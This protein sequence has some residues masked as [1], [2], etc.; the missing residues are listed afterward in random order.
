MRCKNVAS[1]EMLTLLYVVPCCQADNHKLAIE[2][3][4]AIA[5]C[6]DVMEKYVQSESTREEMRVQLQ[7]LK[8]QT[9]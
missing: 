4:S 9:G 3:Q 6:T 5:Q 2:L 1:F 8:Q 7:Q